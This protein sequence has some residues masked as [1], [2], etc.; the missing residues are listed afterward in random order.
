M[1]DHAKP[2]FAGINVRCMS[3]LPANTML[4]SPDVFEKLKD[5]EAAD[6]EL[7]RVKEQFELLTEQLTKSGWKTTQPVRHTSANPNPMQFPKGGAPASSHQVID[8]SAPTTHPKPADEK[9]YL[10]QMIFKLAE[11]GW[12]PCAY[13]DGGGHMTIDTSA[14]GIHWIIEQVSA[15]DQAWLKFE[16]ENGATRTVFLVWGND[17]H[18]EELF[19]D[20]SMG[21]GFEDAIDAAHKEIFPED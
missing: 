2:V 4:V 21:E 12:K 20:H 6:R 9:A 7:T 5:P 3:E 11:R 8:A 15:V 16:N 1:N 19:A 17:P 10:E 13:N 18:G 14:H